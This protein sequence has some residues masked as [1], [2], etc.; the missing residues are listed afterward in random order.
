M[1]QE[2][3]PRGQPTIEQKLEQLLAKEKPVNKK[4]DLKNLRMTRLDNLA[5]LDQDIEDMDDLELLE[6]FE[7][8]E[9]DGIKIEGD[10]L[11]ID[12]NIVVDLPDYLDGIDLDASI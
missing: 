2:I 9:I 10:Q 5:G 1:V 7:N 11:N 8:L 12:I 6:N 4:N 3:K